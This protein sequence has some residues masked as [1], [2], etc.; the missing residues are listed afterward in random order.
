MIGLQEALQ[1]YIYIVVLLDGFLASLLVGRLVPLQLDLP[2][3]EGALLLLH[4]LVDGEELGSFLWRQISFF[5][6]KFLQ[7]CLK[8]L[9]REALL[10][11]LLLLSL[12]SVALRTDTQ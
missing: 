6:D 7:L 3:N 2:D 10:L 4:L 8:L 5:G 11:L 12:L 1:L 9:R